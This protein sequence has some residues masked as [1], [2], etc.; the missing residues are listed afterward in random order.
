MLRLIAVAGLLSLLLPSRLLAAPPVVIP[1]VSPFPGSQSYYGAGAR[2]GALLRADEINANGGI[3]G[4]PLK[5]LFRD[6]GGDARGAALVAAEIARDPKNS[7]VVGHLDA[8]STLAA[9]PIYR[10]AKLVL[11][12]PVASD[13]AVVRSSP[14]L[15]CS[16]YR[17][18]SQGDF[19]ARYARKVRKVSTVAVFCENRD[20]A[21]ALER[22]FAETAG[23]LGLQL[24][25]SQ[26]F[27]MKTVDFTARLARLK[28]LRPELL[29]VI[30]RARQGAMLISQ[31]RLLGLDC[32]FLGSEG[33][34]D[35][36]LLRNPAAG[37]L[38]V[39]TPFLVDRG[40]A[41]VRDF[42]ERYRRKFALEPDWLAA[43]TYDAVG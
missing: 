12:T 5:I 7:V 25:D 38:C 36:S 33:L 9:L 6:D 11:I 37:G 17:V 26:P 3:D 13:P 15:F 39:I 19:L 20:Y 8:V 31:A 30:G 35:G 28:I 27:T 1:V 42:V 24:V 2:N 10:Q 29:L 16:A 14:Y 4:R 32:D 34:D 41:M 18:D 40:R 21:L 43:N 23:G 22:A